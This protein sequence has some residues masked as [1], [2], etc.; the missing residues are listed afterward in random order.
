MSDPRSWW[1]LG[2]AEDS[3]HANG[4]GVDDSLRAYGRG[5]D[6]AIPGTT[7]S[8]SETPMARRAGTM[9]R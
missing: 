5:A 4:D 7:A 2:S 1:A 3:A 6:H 8:W 9:G